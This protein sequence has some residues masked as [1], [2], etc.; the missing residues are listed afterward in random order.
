[1]GKKNKEVIDATCFLA[2][3]DPLGDAGGEMGF[4]LLSHGNGEDSQI[5]GRRRA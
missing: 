3:R 4:S 5:C 2:A 1:M